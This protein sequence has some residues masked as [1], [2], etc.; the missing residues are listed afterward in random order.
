MARSDDA[1]AT[2]QLSLYLNNDTGLNYGASGL[3]IIALATSITQTAMGAVDSIRL[4]L[5]TRAGGA[6]NGDFFE[7]KIPHYRSSLRK[8]LSARINTVGDGTLGGNGVRSEIT[9]GWWED[10]AA[11]TRVDLLLALGNFPTGTKITLYGMR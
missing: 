10:A 6:V 8:T 11:I 1:A 3:A 5:L 9:D 7:I 2:D 4:G